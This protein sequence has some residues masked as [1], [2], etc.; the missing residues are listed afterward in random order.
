M[1]SILFLIILLAITPF[2]N[3]NAAIGEANNVNLH[4]QIDD[5]KLAG[6][7]R[8]TIAFERRLLDANVNVDVSASKVTF[9]GHVNNQLEHD[10]LIEIVDQIAGKA[11]LVLTTQLRILE[12]A[13][14]RSL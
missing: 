3:A 13:M 12:P 4:Q 14:K 5:K 8:S 2:S 1:K 9:Y 7:I 6:M 11:V 10:L